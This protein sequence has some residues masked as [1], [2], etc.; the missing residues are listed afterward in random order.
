M[1]SGS[2]DLARLLDLRQLFHTPGEKIAIDKWQMGG[3][4]IARN[5]QAHSSSGPGRRPLK[6]EITGSTPVCATLEPSHNVP[7]QSTSGLGHFVA[8]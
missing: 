3:Y 8:V 4:H 2:I 7:S 6:A 1:T 5:A